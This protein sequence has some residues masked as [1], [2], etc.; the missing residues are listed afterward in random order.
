MVLGYVFL[1]K[2]CLILDILV[3]EMNASLDVIISLLEIVQAGE[4]IWMSTFD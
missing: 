4:N 1:D 3:S 2:S